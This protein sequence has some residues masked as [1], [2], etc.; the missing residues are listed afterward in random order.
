M[1]NWVSPLLGAPLPD[2]G[3]RALISTVVTLEAATAGA[4]PGACAP[5]A[6]S[7]TSTRSATR[8]PGRSAS[9]ITLLR[10]E[11]ISEFGRSSA[12]VS[13]TADNL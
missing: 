4:L 3:D 13:T 1:L 2:S 7:I 11:D 10:L 6:L 9:W 5:R 8:T 12:R